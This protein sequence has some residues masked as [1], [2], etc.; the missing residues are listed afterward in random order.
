M[1]GTRSHN[2]A[3][4][5]LSASTIRSSVD[6]AARGD[7]RIDQAGIRL[8]G[9]LNRIFKDQRVKITS[10]ALTAPPNQGSGL[11]DLGDIKNSVG[12]TVTVKGKIF[13]IKDIGSMAL[14]DVGAPYPNQLLTL[15]IKGSAK[16]LSDQ[17]NGKMITVKGQVIDYKGKPEI[18]V[19]DPAQITIN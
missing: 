5:T 7:R 17:I 10:V 15:A 9:E 16:S 2:L 8:A 18:I 12:K 11:I 1:G 3:L 13:G 4:G 6:D 19:T 14:A